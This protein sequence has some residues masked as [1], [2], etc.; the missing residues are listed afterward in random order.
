MK[1]YERGVKGQVT[2]FI[3]FAIILLIVAALLLFLQGRGSDQDPDVGHLPVEVM[4]I[5]DF[6]D[7]CLS[8]I[9]KDAVTMLAVQSGYLEIPPEIAD[10][11]NRHLEFSQGFK[12]P[13]WYYDY[14]SYIP[15][16]QMISDQISAYVEHHLP[17][18]LDDFEILKD[19]F[20]IE[21]KSD[22]DVEVSINED[23]VLVFLNYKLKVD[24][25]KSITDV[26]KFY[27]T[28]PVRLGRILDLARDIMESENREAYFEQKTIDIMATE[29][30]IPFTD[31]KFSCLPLTWSVQDIKNKTKK[32]LYA[33]LPLVRVKNTNYRSFIEP[34]INYENPDSTPPE[35]M[36]EYGMFFWDPL[37]T[38]YDDMRIGF[39]YMEDWG[40]KFKAYPSS[41]DVMKSEKTQ[42]GTFQG[43]N[44]MTLCLQFYHF[45]YDIEYPVKVSIY[46]EKSFDTG[47][48]FNFAFPVTVFRNTGIRN[49][50]VEEEYDWGTADDFCS[51]VNPGENV[52]WIRDAFTYQDIEDV[53]ITFS[54]IKYECDLGKTAESGMLRVQL[55]DGC[56]NG[57]VIANKENYLQAA[58]QVGDEDSTMLE[59][60]PLKELNLLVYKYNNETK[61]F[62]NL[63]NNEKAV[64]F[65]NLRNSNYE[66]YATYENTEETIQFTDGMYDAEIYIYNGNDLIGGYT[67]EIEIPELLYSSN[68]IEVSGFIK[69]GATPEEIFEIISNSHNATEIKPK[70]I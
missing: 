12:L 32:M 21:I 1:M 35:D 26:E 50:R 68:S 55:P 34:E 27:S 4:P 49:T 52:I 61:L 40:L 45:S 70:L 69:P 25:G 46:D 62:T 38:N 9:G 24:S 65:F 33:D 20:E 56:K 58:I 48:L 47:Y 54:C 30:T 10:N 53:D 29:N 60:K 66:Q 11:P 19:R 6:V 67:G 59:M 15:S 31:L 23:E 8:T 43:M 17:L 41:G 14:E 64:L 3:I 57:F 42:G 5:S 63:A 18:C 39:S 51:E 37:S 2:I 22:P 16:K 36:V 44:L 13:Y 7:D 28:V